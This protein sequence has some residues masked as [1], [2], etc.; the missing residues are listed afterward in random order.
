MMNTFNPI[1]QYDENFILY[2]IC[3]QTAVLGELLFLRIFYL[4]FELSGIQNRVLRLHFILDENF[5]HAPCLFRRLAE[6]T[7]INSFCE[8]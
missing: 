8:I 7:G 3:T 2:I 4:Y 6:A 1:L 5:H